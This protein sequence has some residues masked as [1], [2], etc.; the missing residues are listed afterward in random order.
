MNEDIT[1][2]EWFDIFSERCSELGYHRRLDKYTFEEDYENGVT[3]E[4]SAK[5]F[6][7][8]MNG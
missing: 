2:D 6:V 4:Y 3:P 1:F 7:D 8:E 5:S